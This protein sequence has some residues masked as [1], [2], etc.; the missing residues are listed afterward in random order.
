M[1]LRNNIKSI[2][3]GNPFVRSNIYPALNNK[4]IVRRS[5]LGYIVIH[6]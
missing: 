5:P 4:A 1:C 3:F 2:F 6:N